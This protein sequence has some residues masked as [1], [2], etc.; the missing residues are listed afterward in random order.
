LLEYVQMGGCLWRGSWGVRRCEVPGNIVLRF[1]SSEFEFVFCRLR[2]WARVIVGKLYPSS[3]DVRPPPRPAGTVPYAALPEVYAEL[4]L[5]IEGVRE[6]NPL[7]GFEGCSR[8][9]EV[10][11]FGAPESYTNVSSESDESS[12]AST[13]AATFAAKIS[14]LVEAMSTPPLAEHTRI[15]RYIR[16]S[17]SFLFGRFRLDGTLD[18]I[19]AFYRF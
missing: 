10:D 11:A 2:L 18:S 3:L 19:T 5:V 6:C 16:S 1:P 14:A 13:T 15:I 4:R 17:R 8:A 7:L 12:L 9:F